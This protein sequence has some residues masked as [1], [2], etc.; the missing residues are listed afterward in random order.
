MRRTLR[1]MIPSMFHRR[2]L[3]LGVVACAVFMLLLARTAMLASGES[4]NQA[5]LD[6]AKSLEVTKVTPT[7]RGRIFDRNGLVL[8]KDIGGYDVAISFELITEDWAIKNAQ[9]ATKFHIRYVANP[10]GKYFTK[11]EEFELYNEKLAEFNNLQSLFWYNLTDLAGVDNEIVQERKQEILKKV[12][13]QSSLNVYWKERRL[14]ELWGEELNWREAEFTIAEE[15]DKFKHIVFRD[16]NKDMQRKIQELRTEAENAWLEYKYAR[17]KKSDDLIEK[18]GIYEVLSVWSGV[19]IQRPRQ[20]VYKFE[21]QLVPM[22]RSTLPKPIR[23]NQVQEVE[24]GGVGLPILGIMRDVYAEDYG[25]GTRRKPYRD[26]DGNVDLKGYRSNDLIGFWGIESTMEDK[27]RGWRGFQTKKLGEVIETVDPIRGEDVNLTIDI[28]LQGRIQALLSKEYGFFKPQLWH[29]NEVQNLPFA[30]SVVVLDVETSEILAAVS[31]PNYT[32][33]Q[34]RDPKTRKKLVQDQVNRPMWFRPAFLHYQP[35][36]TVKPLLYASAV[37]EGQVSTGEM[38]YCGGVF[39]PKTPTR[40]RCWIHKMFMSKHES[41]NGS[42]AIGVSCNIFFYTLGKRMGVENLVKWY[43]KFGIGSRPNSLITGESKGDLPRKD[44]YVT[45]TAINMGIGQ[46]PMT[47]T[48]IQAAAAYATLA[49]GGEYISPTFVKPEDRLD[50]KQVTRNIGLNQAGVMIAL[51][52][53]KHVTTERD[54]GGRFLKYADKS[55]ELI[56]NHPDLDIVGKT[57]TADAA[58][59]KFIYY[60]D[61]GDVDSYGKILKDGD[62]GWFIALV[63]RKKDKHYKYVVLSVVDYGGSGRA[64]SGPIVNQVI[65]AMKAEGYL[66]GENEGDVR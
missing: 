28:F 49:R 30:G 42:K 55:K 4:K 35:G 43:K 61:K 6:C 41:I 19:E 58:A 39:D 44:Q 5:V 47:W 59:Q 15:S 23:S 24:V 40:F 50:N 14:E 3:L 60:D 48:P 21:E 9:F 63:K 66:G 18:R 57:G 8:A 31:A 29:A 1:Q 10:A 56:F 33:K 27:L 45:G 11:A 54:G 46:G 37:T 12:Q 20:R 17:S 51:E 25:E 13:R 38:I 34:Y 65:H 53:L 22:D 36:S 32:L 52:G 7:V 64:A 2:L 16:I 62:H 26:K